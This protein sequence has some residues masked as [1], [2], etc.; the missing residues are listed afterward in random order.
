M[1]MAE[2]IHSPMYII[3]GSDDD[4]HVWLAELCWHWFVWIAESYVGCCVWTLDYVVYKV[5][6][7]LSCVDI[8]LCGLQIVVWIVLCGH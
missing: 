4:W 7:G 3:C 5:L 8:G 6:C 1:G 2:E